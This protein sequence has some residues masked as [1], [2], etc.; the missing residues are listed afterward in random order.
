MTAQIV[1]LQK[2]I[3]LYVCLKMTIT[4]AKIFNK[5]SKKKRTKMIKDDFG[6]KTC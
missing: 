2:R 6:K 3:L 4:V 5:Q 1:L